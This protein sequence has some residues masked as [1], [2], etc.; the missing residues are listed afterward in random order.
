MGGVDAIEIAAVAVL[1]VLAIA[2]ANTLAARLRV[3]A[4]LL[5]VGFGVAVSLLPQVPEF[6]VSPELILVGLLPPLL[7]AAARA[8]PVMDFKRDFQA[9]GALSIVLVIVS[10]LL[11]GLFFNAILPEVDYALGVA[12]GAILSPTDAV[13]TGTIKRLGAPNRIV[14][15]LSGESLF[16]DA[17]ALVLLRAAIAA[18]AASISFAGVVVNFVWSLLGA[19]VV[20]A[21]VGWLL[22]RLRARIRNPA[23]ATAVSFTAP[24]VAYLPAELIGSSGLVAAVAAGLVGGRLAVRRLSAAH[25]LSDIQNWRMVEVILEGAVFLL[26][27]LEL[28]TLLEDVHDS[29]ETWLHALWPA[30]VALV[31]ALAIRWVFVMPLVWLLDRRAQRMIAR[32]P[33]LEALREELPDDPNDDDT[34]GFRYRRRLDRSLADINY[35]RTEAMGSREAMVVVWGGLRG[36]VTLAA[37]QTLPADTPYRS[38]LI[39]VA[40][41][42]AALSL[43]IQGGLMETV[44]RRLKLPDQSADVRAEKMRL[45]GE[46]LGVAQQ[47]LTDPQVTGDDPI[48]ANQVR[49][50]RELEVPDVDDSDS[51]IDALDRRLQ[52]ARELRRVRRMVIDEQRRTLLALRDRGTYSSSALTAELDK[53]DAEEM[54]LNG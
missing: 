48:L 49:L 30:A 43:A 29:H 2:A 6:H 17:S 40:F 10:S 45:R 52:T 19:M 26:M 34:A 37:A 36:A 15:V 46:M 5:L 28:Y 24:Y 33:T 53:L 8:M 21:L 18:S 7:Y 38:L 23:V 44:L 22:N 16:N 25:R 35:Y 41:F 50:V 32:E 14:T 1:C 31:M 3:A 9:I 11:L 4:P 39:L 47:M 42:V 12:L 13:A 51:E 27:G 54:S 20:G